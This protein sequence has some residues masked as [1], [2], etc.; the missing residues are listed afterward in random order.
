MEDDLSDLNIF[1]MKRWFKLA[2]KHS[3]RSTHKKHKL[4]AV[5]VRSGS[6]LSAAA[7]LGAWHRCSELRAIKKKYDY[8]GATIVVA[9]SNM[10]CSKP[11]EKCQVFIKNAGIKT[12]GYINTDGVFV[13]ERVGACL[14]FGEF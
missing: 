9:R 3:K 10:G 5:I 11:C 13:M 12:M 1:K 14:R 4:G 2:L 8:T 6:V 7:N